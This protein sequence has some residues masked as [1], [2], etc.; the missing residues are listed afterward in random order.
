MDDL[1]RSGG[2][3]TRRHPRPGED[4]PPCFC[5]DMRVYNQGGYSIVRI[6]RCGYQCR[7]PIP[8]DIAED[9]ATF[10]VAYARDRADLL[11]DQ[12]HR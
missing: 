12:Q 1:E 11:H 7:V 10:V 2:Y 8:D 4:P 5:T 6:Y 9:G 3:P